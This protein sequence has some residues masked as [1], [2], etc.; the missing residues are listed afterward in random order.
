MSNPIK[1][2]IKTEILPLTVII[3]TAAASIYFY[4]HF[5]ASV[6]IHWNIKGEVDNWGTPTMAAFSIPAMLIGMYLLFL[7]IP[8]LDPRKERYEDFAKIY[9]FFRTAI[10][11]L[12]S[13]VYFI[14]SLNGLGYKISV[15]FWTPILIGSLFILLGN[16]MGKIKSNWFVGVRTPWTLSSEENW[17]KSN[18]M[19]GRIFVLSGLLF[20]FMPFL[21]TIFQ[22]TLFFLIIT[23]LIFGTTGYSFFLYLKDQKNKKL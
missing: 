14:A 2:T 1:P 3:L 9:S 11:T 12:L 22:V 4:Y 18:R 7:F 21:P 16:Y 8:Y 5:P 20:I 17:N 10:I 23:A 13:L 19:G 15:A 6:P